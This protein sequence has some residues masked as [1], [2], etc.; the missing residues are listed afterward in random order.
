[1]LKPLIEQM[2]ADPGG[3]R[4]SEWLSRLHAPFFGEST[5]SPEPMHVVALLEG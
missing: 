4:V 5:C 1:M 2:R 3:C